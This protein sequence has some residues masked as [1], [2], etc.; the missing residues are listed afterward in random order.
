MNIPEIWSCHIAIPCE[1]EGTPA[2]CHDGGAVPQEVAGEADVLPSLRRCVCEQFDRYLLS[3][4][5]QM[6]DPVGAVVAS[7][8]AAID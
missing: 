7:N 1:V 4:A 3:P 2:R 8:R 5:T 6:V